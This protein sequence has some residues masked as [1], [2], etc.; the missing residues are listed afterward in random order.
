MNRRTNDVHLS[1]KIN[2]ANRP[3]NEAKPNKP[4]ASNDAA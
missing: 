1:T 3:N 2:F 4:F